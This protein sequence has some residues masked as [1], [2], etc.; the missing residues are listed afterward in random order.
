MKKFFILCAALVLLLSACSSDEQTDQ[1]LADGP[2]AFQCQFIK[3]GYYLAENAPQTALLRNADEASAYYKEITDLS[4]F[5]LKVTSGAIQEMETYFSNCDAAFYEKYDLLVITVICSSGGDKYTVTDVCKEGDELKITVSKTQAGMTC[6]MSGCHL[7][8]TLP[9]SHNC[10][11][12]NI[13][14]VFEK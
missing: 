6:D 12:D 2:V 8:V 11:P 5:N 7:M 1:P 14:I 9:K 4:D 3:T 10:D 13:H